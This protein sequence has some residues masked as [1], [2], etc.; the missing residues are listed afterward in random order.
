MAKVKG[1]AIVDSVRYLRRHKD[2]ARELLAPELHHYLAERVLIASWY[3]EEDLVPLVRAMAT[4]QGESEDAFFDKAGRLAAYTHAQG[5]YRL[6]MRDGA[7]ESLARRAFILWTSQHD[8]GSMEMHP[9]EDP[10]RVCVELRGFGAPTREFC[11]INGGY[12]A[13]TFEITGCQQV[14]TIKESC[15]VDGDSECAWQVSWD[16][17][18]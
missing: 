3:P 5:V 12:I 9:T 13:A 1:A 4:I 14:R 8:T 18:D 17:K 15:C 10:N 7:R 2:E 11:R 16:H 6:L